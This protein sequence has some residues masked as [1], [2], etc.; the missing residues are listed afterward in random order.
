M[1]YLSHKMQGVWRIPAQ[2][3]NHTV[4]LEASDQAEV[5]ILARGRARL[6]PRRHARGKMPA[7]H[8]REGAATCHAVA[9]AKADVRAVVFRAGG[10]FG[11]RISIL[12]LICIKEIPKS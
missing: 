9:L 5:G 8:V 1:Y 10:A 3:Q 4:G 2:T 11:F 12:Y 6:R 7:Y